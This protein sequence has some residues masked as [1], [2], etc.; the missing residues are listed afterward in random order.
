M[1][2]D[3]IETMFRRAGLVPEKREKVGDYEVFIGDG[4]SAPPHHAYTRFGVGPDEFSFGCYV[5]FWWV[6]KDE[7]LDTGH[8]LFFDAFHN[9][10]YDTATKKQARINSALKDAVGF[11]HTRK[12]VALNG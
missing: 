7:K 9:P 2:K 4:F 8:P 5:T 3:K 6:A 12:K 11:L 1:N 10:E